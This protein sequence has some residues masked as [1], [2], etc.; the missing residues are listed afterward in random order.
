MVAGLVGLDAI[1]LILCVYI[2]LPL[3]YIL[4]FFS[5]RSRDTRSSRD[6]SSDVCSSDL[7]FVGLGIDFGIQF[8]V[9]YRAE[10][11][12]YDDLRKALHSAAMKAGG[13]LALAAA[14]TAVGFSS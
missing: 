13:P 4:F 9:R 2:P 6:W 1:V 12:D 5:S 3:H 10:R 11:H 14:A 7:L 8:S